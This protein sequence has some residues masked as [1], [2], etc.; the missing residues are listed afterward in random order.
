MVVV[1][2]F[3]KDKTVKSVYNTVKFSESYSRTITGEYKYD[4]KGRIIYY[5]SNEYFGRGNAGSGGYEATR[6]IYKREYKYI[7]ATETQPL[8]TQI[9]QITNIDSVIVKATSTVADSAIVT[10]NIFSLSYKDGILVSYPQANPIDKTVIGLYNIGY[11]YSGGNMTSRTITLDNSTGVN[12][13]PKHV[14][15]TY[16]DGNIKQIKAG[17]RTTRLIYQQTPK[18]T[19]LKLNNNKTIT[20][21]FNYPL[22][23]TADV[24]SM[25]AIREPALKA[26]LPA[27]SIQRAYVNP[28]NAKELV[29][30]LNRPLEV[31]EGFELYSTQDLPLKDGRFVP[32][33]LV[34]QGSAATG[35]EQNVVGEITVLNDNGTVTVSAP[36]GI[37]S[38]AMYSVAGMLV[39][40]AD[41]GN[42]SEATISVGA[43]SAGVYYVHVTDAYGNTSV[44]PVAIGK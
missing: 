40:A 24:K 28:T 35:A 43:L 30:E 38:A 39:A 33:S 7:E 36:Q 16:E 12:E 20:I 11:V 37:A 19:A 44:Q 21:S 1:M 3:N 17:D 25:L 15:F 29:I 32:V 10:S 18:S 13:A 5:S 6:K 9:I 27:L 42:G 31:R 14:N 8:L 2:E 4:D 34:A 26:D 22:D 41:A 23:A